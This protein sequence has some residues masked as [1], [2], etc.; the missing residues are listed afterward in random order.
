M[1]RRPP[2]STLFPYTTLFRSHELLEL[3]ERFL[4]EPLVLL[5]RLHLVVV[6]HRQAVLDE[7][8]DLVAGEERE[9][10]LE[11]LDRLVELRLAIVGL[12]HKEAATR[13]IRALRVALDDLL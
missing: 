11:L 8:S 6:A 4:R 5:D 1:I 2:R 10:G 3:V 13:R 9:E 12:A 7:I